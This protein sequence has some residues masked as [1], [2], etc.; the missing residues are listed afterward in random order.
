MVSPEIVRQLQLT[1]FLRGL[2]EGALHDLLEDMEHRSYGPGNVIV[3]AGDPA[4]GLYLI[5]HGSVDLV[6]ADRDGS[7]K[8]VGREE[9]GA[10]LGAHELLSATPFMQSIEAVEPTELLLWDKRWLFPFL[11]THPASLASL[12]LAGR[13]QQLGRSLQFHWLADDESIF[14]LARKHIARLGFR[15]IIPLILL[16]LGV[17]SGWWSYAGGGSLFGWLAPAAIVLALALGGWQWVDWRNDYYIVTDQRVI[18]L[19]KVVAIYDSR[20]EAPLHQVLAVTVS[21]DMLGRW[22]GYGDVV[23][24]TYTGQIVFRTVGAPRA[25]AAVVEER[26]RR[27]QLTE[28]AESWATKRETVRQL[29][30]GEPA[31]EPEAASPKSLPAADNKP[32]QLDPAD[33]GLN[34]WNLELRFE[35]QG[36]I[37]YRKHWAVLLGSIA[38]PS[39]L[40][41]L[42]VGLAGARLGGLITLFSAGI[43]LAI[44]G[45]V[46]LLVAGWWIYSFVDWANDI[47]QIS[48]T[49]ILDV[50]RKPLGRELRQAAPLENILSTEVDRRGI[51]GLLLDFGAVRVN[52]GSEQLDFEG[53]FHPGEVQQDIVRAQEAFL[54]RRRG[55]EQDQRRRE[56]VEWLSAYHEE[57]ASQ[58]P[59]PR[60][61]LDFDDYP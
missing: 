12:R 45:A 59:T 8:R 6:Q 1:H 28:E 7:A 22:L 31:E 50:Y 16:A 5:L 14:A 11:E 48:P 2:T 4:G 46:G 29:L 10:I 53:V 18:W 49:H 37:T 30:E 15:L 13:S 54:A 33:I 57:V 35:R 58:K 3:R 47:Y 27:L 41:L 40:L 20:V 26:W 43:S 32:E 21:T 23:V 34:H 25:M 19:E 42:A 9:A 24:R 56:M 61:D 36:V 60:E 38:L 52:I 55:Q 39:L 44:F 17:G 51:F